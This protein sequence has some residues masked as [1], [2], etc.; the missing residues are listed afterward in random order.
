[1]IF[2][3]IILIVFFLSIFVL[4]TLLTSRKY[5]M[6]ILFKKAKNISDFID[7]VLIWFFFL[8]LVLFI[9]FG[10]VILINHYI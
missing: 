10:I 7:R 5:V 4:I 8:F 3:I 9:I 1:M 6:T 2:E